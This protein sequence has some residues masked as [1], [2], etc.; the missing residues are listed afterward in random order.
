MIIIGIQIQI[1]IIDKELE[2]I[3]LIMAMEWFKDYQF[4][5]KNQKFWKKL[6]KIEL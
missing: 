2:M 4:L 1:Q 6:I 5:L 3:I